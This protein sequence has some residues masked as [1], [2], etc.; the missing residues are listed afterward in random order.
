[1]ADMEVNMNGLAANFAGSS[2]LQVPQ[3]RWVAVRVIAMNCRRT[4]CFLAALIPVASPAQDRCTV[5]GQADQVR[6]EREFS[7][8]RPARGDKEAELTWSKNLNAALAAAAKR[9][10][11][12]SRA[13]KPAVAPAASARVEECLADVRRRTDDLNRRDRGRTLTLQEQTA[14]RSE[15]ER[16]LDEYMAC[17]RNTKR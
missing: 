7:G 15:D 8:Q 16:L 12:C 13:S 4:I 2:Q 1:M 3:N 10:E 6:I 17:T 5:Q 11:D 14:R 9:A